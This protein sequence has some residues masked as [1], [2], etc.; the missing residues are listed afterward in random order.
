MEYFNVS[1]YGEWDFYKE[2]ARNELEYMD[3]DLWSSLGAIEKRFYTFVSQLD[4]SE[5]NPNDLEIMRGLMP[6]YEPEFPLRDKT[7]K[8]L[9]NEY[10]MHIGQRMMGLR[11]ARIITPYL[12]SENVKVK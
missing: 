9:F 10:N 8:E 12:S 4:K 1:T 11:A 6:E 7:K 2:K 5:Y 3:Q